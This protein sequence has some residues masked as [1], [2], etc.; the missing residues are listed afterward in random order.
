MGEVE[1]IH[2]QHARAW[3]GGAWHGPSVREALEGV[4]AATAAARPVKDAHGIWEIVLHL[5]AW[6]GAVRDRLGG[7][8]R[9]VPAEG[10]WPGVGPTD[11]AAWRAALDELAGRGRRLREAVAELDDPDLARPV[12]GKPYDVYH[13]LHGAVQHALYH[14]G[15][16]VLLRKAAG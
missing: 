4:D 11:S 3:E 16:V 1:R 6:E 12:P 2:D 7:I 8:V 14:A 9:P 15:Q 5:S 10:D 13:L